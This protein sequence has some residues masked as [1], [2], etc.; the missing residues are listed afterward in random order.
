MRKKRFLLK[1]LKK[2]FKYLFA[3]G[4]FVLLCKHN[5]TAQQRQIRK[6][7]RI[8]LSLRSKLAVR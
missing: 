4:V 5:I 8:K 2:M 6:L 3:F 1:K 7:A